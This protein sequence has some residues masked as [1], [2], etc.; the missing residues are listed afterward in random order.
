MLVA[1]QQHRTAPYPSGVPTR[2]R[3]TVSERRLVLVLGAV[4]FT[5]TVFYAAI[6]PLLPSLVHQLH[7]SKLSAGVMTAMYPIGTFVGSIPGGMLTVRIGP[8]RTVYVGLALLAVSTLAFGWL[9]SVAALDAARFVEGVGGAFSWA[10]ALA[11]LVADVPANRRG[12]RIGGALGAAIAGALF[13]P[14]IGVIASAV[15]R[16][17]AFSGVVVLA[18]VLIDQ[19]RRIPLRHTPSTQRVRD[20]RVV[21]S[22]REVRSAMWLVV[23]PSLASGMVSVLGP[24]RLHHLGADAAAI[25]GVY[26]V[27]AGVE[28]LLTPVVGRFSDRRGRLLPLRAGLTGTA[29]AVVCFTLP[30]SAA[31]LGALIVVIAAVLATFWAPSMAMLS[32]SAE[33]VGLEQGL[34]A[35][36]INI[37]WAAGQ[38]VGAV[39][40]GAVAKALGDG[41]PMAAAAALALVTLVVLGFRPPRQAAA[42]PTAE[43][44][45]D[46]QMP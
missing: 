39:G 26:L 30:S 36:L 38:T 24:L 31:L 11:W 41:A 18:I 19:A 13:G 23:L 5:D 35:A 28:A 44:V 33:S 3:E 32:E 40:G 34:A 45:A 42:A 4:V 7:M 2:L 17:P 16:G 12:E 27:A 14:V 9:H 20:L 25:G 10:G 22:D 37:A 6:A 8:K 46:A 29:A 21:F 43:P 1:A 15:G